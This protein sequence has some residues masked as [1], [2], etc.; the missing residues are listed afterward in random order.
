[1]K[2]IIQTMV[3]NPVDKDVE[4]ELST[5]HR[6]WVSRTL[7]ALQKGFFRTETMKIFLKELS[8]ITE[9]FGP[10]G[11]SINLVAS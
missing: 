1:M 6:S 7:N 4:V 10:K 5:E 3:Q 8:Q 9:S 11:E 2:Y